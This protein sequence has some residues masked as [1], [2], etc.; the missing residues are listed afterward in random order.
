VTRHKALGER[1][2]FG[3]GGEGD[4]AYTLQE[5]HSHGVIV[6]NDQGGDSVNVEKSDVAPTLRAETHGNLPIVYDARGNGSGK[7]APT[8]VGDHQN[9]VTDYTALAVHQNQCGEVRTGDVANTISTNGNASGR[10]AP[11]VAIGIDGEQNAIVE[12]MGTIRAHSS[13]GNE[14]CVGVFAMQG[15]GDYKESESASALKS[16]DFKDA[17]DLVGYGCAVRRL[18]PTECERLQG[19]PDGWTAHGHDGRPISDTQRYR[20]LGNSVAIPCVEFIMGNIRGV[21]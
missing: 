13:G 16:R 9:R 5:G 15:F 11:L 8:I 4:P 20:A 2:A 7:V 6:L 18:T 17:T 10:N 19:F 1:T 21:M 14:H 3:M 12:K